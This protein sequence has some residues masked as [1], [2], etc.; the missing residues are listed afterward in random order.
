MYWFW[1]SLRV[2]LFGV[3]VGFVIG[4]IVGVLLALIGGIA[5][6]HLRHS[7]RFDPQLKLALHTQ[8]ADH[9]AGK[10]IAPINVEVSPSGVCQASCGFCFYA[11]GELGSHRKVFLDTGVTCDLLASCAS[12]GVKSI[13]WTG[14]GEP[15]L[16]PDIAKLVACA[17]ADGIEQGMFTNALAMPRFDPSLLSWARVTMTDKPYKAECIKALRPAKALGFAFNYSGEQDDAYLRETLTLAEQVQADYVQVRPA[18]AFHGAT[19]DI[20]PPDITHPLL[21]VTSYKFAEAKKPHEY[22][23]CEGYKFVPFVWE[24]GDVAVC[25]YM[26]KH[27]GYV[28]GN[29]YNKSFS[30]ILASAPPSVPVIPSCQVCCRNHEFNRA[31]HAARSVEDRN[32]P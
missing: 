17:H 13:S 32:F 24:D 21:V 6:Y 16:H 18:L 30:D 20:V 25:S 22:A 14:G 4:V 11:G 15:S 19:V 31:V 27:E 3:A 9:L 1:D 12:L 23:T 2:W 5:L 26:R 7:M 28:L 8:F 29:L 10:Q